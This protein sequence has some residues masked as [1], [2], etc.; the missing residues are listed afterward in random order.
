M[1]GSLDTYN[2]GE[3]LVSVGYVW[4]SRE[5]YYT[6]VDVHFTAECHYYECSGDIQ[7]NWNIWGSDNEDFYDIYYSCS[8][9]DSY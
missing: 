1:E 8:T 2:D 5:H 6:E 3:C 9:I 7:C 4:G